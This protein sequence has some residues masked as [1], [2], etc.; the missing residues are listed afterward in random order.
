MVSPI[1][2]KK[3]EK[4]EE[5]NR[6]NST[7]RIPQVYFFRSFFGRIED[8]IYVVKKGLWARYNGINLKKKKN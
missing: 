7:I 3:I 2:P 5:K 8:T 6:P 4:K 1:L